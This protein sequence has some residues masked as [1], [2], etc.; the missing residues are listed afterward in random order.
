VIFGRVVDA[1]TGQ[2]LA[3]AD[4]TLLDYGRMGSIVTNTSGEFVF[5][6]VPSGDHQL[7]VTRSGY[8]WGAFGTRWAGVN[9]PDAT[10]WWNYLNGQFVPLAA[11]E[12]KN[13]EIHMWKWL[14]ISG[15]VVDEA[16]DP[17]VGAAVEAWPRMYAGGHPWLNR[18]Y[19]TTGRTDDRGVF[20]LRYLLPGD[21]AVVFPSP[22]LTLPVDR[23]VSAREFGKTDTEIFRTLAIYQPVP[24]EPRTSDAS[25]SSHGD[26]RVA[27]LGQPVPPSIEG[28]PPRGYPTTFY[29]ATI[30][31]DAATLVTLH[32]GDRR[33]GINLTLAPVRTHAISGTLTSPVGAVPQTSIVLYQRGSDAFADVQVAVAFSQVDGRFAFLDVPPGAY[34]LEVEA[35]PVAEVA[36]YSDGPP[37][38]VNTG[39]E[40]AE[41]RVAAPR[42]EQ[43]TL[44]ATAPVTVGDTDVIDVRVL[45]QTGTRVTGRVVFDS[46]TP[47]KVGSLTTLE[48]GFERADGRTLSVQTLKEID[49]GADASLRS[50]ELPGGKYFV[51]ASKLPD[52]WTLQSVTWRGRDL[53]VAPLECP[54]EGPVEV[55]VTLTD[56]PSDISGAVTTRSN[57]PDP[58]A[59]VV[60]FPRD[61]AAWIDFGTHPRTIATRRVDATGHYMVKGL[62]PGDYWIVGVDDALLS[63][64]IGPPLLETLSRNATLLTVAPDTHARKDLITQ[65]VR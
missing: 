17:I 61:P 37:Y 29:S 41:Y 3:Y 11:G 21:Y 65:V 50:V 56:R 40:G 28:E 2:P 25:G 24:G 14:T 36:R 20:M 58:D 33:Q 18:V 63:V 46:A 47:H 22:S 31:P 43:P 30:S 6:D 5:F 26:F 16:G 12:T 8:F 45:L 10:R 15:R 62:P 42:A 60:I 35:P 27:R 38:V 51:R 1:D 52:G 4:V 7:I 57:A 59:S 64:G 49:V 48:L 53:S 39:S 44:W 34:R 9:L 19:A 54:A 55:V 23:G 32:P 13:I